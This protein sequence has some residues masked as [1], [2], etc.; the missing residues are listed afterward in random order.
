MKAIQ[1]TAFGTRPKLVEVDK[2]TPGLGEVLLRITA[3]G[4]ATRTS[5]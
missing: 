3:R 1:Y 4:C 5:S 2:P